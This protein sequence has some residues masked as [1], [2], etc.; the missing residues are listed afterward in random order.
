MISSLT[1]LATE[2]AGSWGDM[3]VTDESFEEYCKAIRDYL[4]DEMDWEWG[5][6]L[7]L[8]VASDEQWEDWWSILEE[9]A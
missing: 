3:S 9:A 7:D 8:L 2:L 6:D 1:D 4:Y 5:M